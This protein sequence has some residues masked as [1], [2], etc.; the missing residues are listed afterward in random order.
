MA[1]RV[2]V[3]FVTTVIR[4]IEAA[5]THSHRRRGHGGRVTMLL[6]SCVCPPLG[7]D[8]PICWQWRLASRHCPLRRGHARWLRL[9]ATGVVRW[10]WWCHTVSAEALTSS[11]CFIVTRM[12]VQRHPGFTQRITA[13]RA[14]VRASANTATH[15][16]PPHVVVSAVAVCACVGGYRVF[17]FAQPWRG[18]IVL[19]VGG[20]IQ[21]GRLVGVALHLVEVVVR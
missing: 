21:R 17:R 10:R 1:P 16:D 19:L 11:L 7:R 3:L 9:V 18:A 2:V 5:A 15:T 20:P 13:T 14:A 12:R 6:H 4:G 8:G